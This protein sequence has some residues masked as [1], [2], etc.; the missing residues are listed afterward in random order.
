MPSLDFL[1]TLHRSASINAANTPMIQLPA[2]PHACPVCQ[3]KATP[4][5]VV[6]F[7]KSCVEERGAYLSLSGVPIYYFLCEECNFLF[8]PEFGA[9]APED[10]ASHIYNADYHRVD[11]DF[12]GTRSHVNAEGLLKLFPRA[13]ALRHLDYGGGEGHLSQAL[14]VA[15]W[16][17]RSYDPYAGRE[18]PL[19]E[20]ARFDLIT[21]FEVFEHVAQ[22]RPLLDTLSKHLQTP[23]LL[24]FSTL[25][26]DGHLQRPKRI[27]WWY[28]SP[29]NGHISIYSERSLRYLAE[30]Y[31]FRHKSP[32]PGLHFFWKHLPPWAEH[33]RPGLE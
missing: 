25:L 14:Q 6:D 8:A 13:N 21:S 7:N 12:D 32:L 3:G 27:D 29:R 30:Q 9:W 15:G 17:S 10:F 23:G 16:N 2:N 18:A 19:G 11:P 5:D 33:L 4:Y 31:G 20:D 28:I 26:S 22:P 24:I 1:H